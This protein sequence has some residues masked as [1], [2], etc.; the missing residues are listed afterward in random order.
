MYWLQLMDKYAA[1]WSVLIIAIIECTLI[2]WKYGSER[3]LN[4]IQSMIGKR[5]RVW[6]SFW[7]LMWKFV[8]PAV[9]L[10]NLPYAHTQIQNI[11]TNNKCLLKCCCSSFCSS[12]GWN[13][14][15][16]PMESMCI[17]Y[18]LMQSDGLWDYCLFL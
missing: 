6:I 13:I 2:A 9:L 14:S 3:F 5:G 1:N 16:L 17:R 12:I 11:F 7:T 4:D 15:Q 10:V 8:T 18:G